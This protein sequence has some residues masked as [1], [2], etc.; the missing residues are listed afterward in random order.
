MAEEKKKKEKAPER[1]ETE[2][3]EVTHYFG[4][5]GVAVVKA[6]KGPIKKG[7]KL[8][9]VGGSS[10]FDQEVTSIQVDH[11]D[12]DGLAKGKEGG[13]KVDSKVHEGNK[14]YRIG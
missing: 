14:I 13:M 4:H 12:V 7:D 8:H 1:K 2:V 3:G 11:K 6:T 10:D 9:L 5:I